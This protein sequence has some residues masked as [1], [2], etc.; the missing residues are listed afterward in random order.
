MSVS[1]TKTRINVCLGSLSMD[2][3]APMA[4]VRGHYDLP[5]CLSHFTVLSLCNQLYPVFSGYLSNLVYLLC[6][7]IK[8][9][10]T[11]SWLFELSHFGHLFAL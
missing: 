2:F 5:I 6:M 1:T 10:F 7:E 3:Y 11:E 9:I 4:I 8:V